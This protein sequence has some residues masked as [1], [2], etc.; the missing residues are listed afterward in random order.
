MDTVIKSSEIKSVKTK[1]SSKFW[2]KAEFDH[3][4]IIPILLVVVG[5]M[6]GLA[7]GFEAHSNTLKL[8]IV[9][10]PT[11]ISLSLT[12]VASSMRLIFLAAAITIVCDLIVII[13]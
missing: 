6:G 13:W 5:I 4:G 8:A 7:V 9:V 12:V 3:L 2:E 10:F 11:V 1:L